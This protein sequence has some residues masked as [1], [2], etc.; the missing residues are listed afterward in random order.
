MKLLN[1]NYGRASTLYGDRSY[2]ASMGCLHE[3]KRLDSL[4]VLQH[5]AFVVLPVATLKEL[6]GKNLRLKKSKNY[7]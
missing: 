6:I 1:M 2:V 5:V 7:I 4:A 3:K